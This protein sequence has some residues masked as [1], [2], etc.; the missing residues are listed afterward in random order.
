MISVPAHC[1]KPFAG[2]VSQVGFEFLVAPKSR[3]FRRRCPQPSPRMESFSSASSNGSP[4]RIQPVEPGAYSCP[5]C[6]LL[7]PTQHTCMVCGTPRQS[8]LKIAEQM[9]KS[10]ENDAVLSKSGQLAALTQV[11]ILVSALSLNG[12]RKPVG[13]P[14]FR[15]HGRPQVI[16]NQDKQPPSHRN[17]LEYLVMCLQRP[18]C[19][20][21]TNGLTH[22]G[23]LIASY[24]PMPHFP[25]SQCLEVGHGMMQRIQGRPLTSICPLQLLTVAVGWLGPFTPSQCT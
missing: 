3:C 6:N 17:Q 21:M 11:R 18:L 25:A 5:I 4:L 7:S 8:P 14:C 19:H 9:V 16:N 24:G 22:C 10:V 23:P 20:H 1:S 2:V 13:F 12:A 15:H